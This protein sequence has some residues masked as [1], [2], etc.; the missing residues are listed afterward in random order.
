M[1]AHAGLGELLQQGSGQ[2]EDTLGKKISS[3]TVS[4]LVFWHDSVLCLRS[5]QPQENIFPGNWLP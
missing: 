3:V 1:L 5:L 2:W 4:A